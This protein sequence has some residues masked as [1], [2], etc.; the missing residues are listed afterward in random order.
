MPANVS[1]K[2]SCEPEKKKELEDAIAELIR[3]HPAV[4]TVNLRE[5][6]TD[7]SWEISILN[8]EGKRV[9]QHTLT[10]GGGEYRVAEVEKALER[11]PLLHKQ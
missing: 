8:L 4:L 3:D 10:G 1:I 2:V 6:S 5:E 7:D 9:W 11:S